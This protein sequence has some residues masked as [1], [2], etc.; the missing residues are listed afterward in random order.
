M[1]ILKD[2]VETQDRPASI[3][4]N[5]LQ[6]VVQNQIAEILRRDEEAGRNISVTGEPEVSLNIPVHSASRLKA[7]FGELM[8]DLMVD[9]RE[10]RTSVLPH[11]G[12]RELIQSFA[13]SMRA[14]IDRPRFGTQL[15]RVLAVM[16]GT[17]D[18]QGV[19]THVGPLLK[20]LGI[21]P[22]P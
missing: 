16:D 14:G 6:Q 5:E 8:T 12:R 7:Q 20:T 2:M 1:V 22:R 13:S 15:S 3:A 4:P 17:P 9:H 11:A 21:P 18:I 19:G 10:A